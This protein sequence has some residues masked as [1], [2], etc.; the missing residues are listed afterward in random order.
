M[1]IITEINLIELSEDNLL[2]FEGGSF[3]YDIGWALY[4]GAHGAFDGSNP[5]ATA[6]AFKA[7]NN[8]YGN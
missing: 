6:Q 1:E 7:Y 2:T 8:H 5:Y 4:W 3:G